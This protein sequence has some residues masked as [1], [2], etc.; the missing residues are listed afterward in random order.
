MQ[1]V[2]ALSAI[3]DELVSFSTEEL[4]GQGIEPGAVSV[5]RRVHLR[6]EGTD[7]ALQ[8]DYGSINEMQARFELAY[9]QR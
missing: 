8:V 3:L 4:A 6:Y 9:R 7:T 5:L 2:Q 1:S